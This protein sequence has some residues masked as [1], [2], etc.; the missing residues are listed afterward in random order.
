MRINR[1]R[2]AVLAVAAVATLSAACSCLETCRAPGSSTAGH[3]LV[4]AVAHPNRALAHALPRTLVSVSVDPSTL[5]VG[6]I[7][8]GIQQIITQLSDLVDTTSG[9]LKSVIV[10]MQQ[11][12]QQ[13][14]ADLSQRFQND[15]SAVVHDLSTE[16]Q[17]I[18]LEAANAMNSMQAAIAQVSAA[19]DATAL[20]AMQDADITAYDALYDIPC[21]QQVPRA[22]YA[23]PSTV[24]IWADPG[25][26]GEGANKQ[27]ISFTIRGN[28]MD[29]YGAPAVSVEGQQAV[30]AGHN[31]NE[32]DID[33]SGATITSLLNLQ[34]SELLVLK[35]QL[36][37]CQGNTIES[38]VSVTIEPPIKYQITGRIA[39]T[40][41]IPYSGKKSY[42]FYQMG[43]CTSNYSVPGSYPADPGTNVTDCS[44]SITTANCGSGV[45]SVVPAGNV[46]AVQA[47]IIGCGQDCFLGICNCKGRGW[48]GYNLSLSYDGMQMQ[49]LPVYEIPPVTNGN[50]L[51]YVFPYQP[52][53]PPNRDTTQTTCDYYLRIVQQQGGSS[54]IVELTNYTPTPAGYLVDFNTDD[55]SISLTIPPPS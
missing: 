1:N 45:N 11:S 53:L 8:S 47:Q 46:C 23:T 7:I 49:P 44:V 15:L 54:Q 10:Q 27:N 35:T 4:Q 21:R 50:Q 5:L 26:P 25:A 19:A 30:V 41:D 36:T 37:G 18:A 14:E 42:P 2:I 48:L 33:L 40:V 38:D 3:A 55:C 20:Q 12:A 16:N 32:V 22:V 29:S 24:R 17:H 43:S 51:S 31:P 13:L 52:G 28:Y 6:Q 34:Q 39:P 9:D